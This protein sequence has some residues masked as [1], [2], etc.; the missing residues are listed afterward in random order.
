MSYNNHNA[1][2]LRTLYGSWACGTFDNNNNYATIGNLKEAVT[3]VKLT[4]SVKCF[5]WEVAA[6]NVL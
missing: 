3:Q 5:T 4:M 6:N 1:E 2:H